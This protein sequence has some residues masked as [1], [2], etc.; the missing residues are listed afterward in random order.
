MNTSRIL[1]FP[2]RR[3]L[4]GALVIAIGIGEQQSFSGRQPKGPDGF[5]WI[6]IHHRRDLG[7]QQLGLSLQ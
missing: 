1:P 7:F 5:G 2:P 6:F 3:H 4:N